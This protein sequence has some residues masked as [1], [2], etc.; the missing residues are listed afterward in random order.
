MIKYK[1]MLVGIGRILLVKRYRLIDWDNRIL[2]Y[3][4]NVSMTKVRHLQCLTSKST[5]TAPRSVA[6]L[7]T[8]FFPLNVK[9]SV[10]QLVEQWTGE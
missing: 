1:A 8:I 5:N 10:A 9:A 7:E 4:E 6:R 3:L 2:E